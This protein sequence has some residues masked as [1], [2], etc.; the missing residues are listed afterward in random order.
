MLFWAWIMSAFVI[1]VL[2]KKWQEDSELRPYVIAVTML[3]TT[4]FVGVVVFITNPF[5]KLWI[6]PGAENLVRPS[7][8][9]AQRNIST[10]YRPEPSCATLA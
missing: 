10:G 5:Q 3:T 4:F 1:T 6:V 2:L 7:G 8:R 9:L